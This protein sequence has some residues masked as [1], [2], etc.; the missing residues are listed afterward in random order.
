MRKNQLDEM[1]LQKRN[2]IGNQSFLLLSYL[3]MLDIA[4]FGFGVRWLAY[5]VNVFLIILVSM[6]YYSIRTI[7]NSA[8]AGPEETNGKPVKRAAYTAAIGVITAIAAIFIA[9]SNLI[10][11]PA[12]VEG[13]KGAS[14]LFVAAVVMLL[15][16]GVV[17]IIA[18][19]R[20]REKDE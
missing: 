1:Q 17:G 19:R 9:K 5:P 2:A 16:F 3:L 4:L 14:I 12:V 18:F 15:I 11:A 8:F 13:D 20:N 10:K 6:A 7:W